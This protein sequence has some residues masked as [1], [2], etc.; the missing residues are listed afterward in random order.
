[1]HLSVHRMLRVILAVGLVMSVQGQR[2]KLKM[3][4]LI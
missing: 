1:M 2:C 4:L 3:H